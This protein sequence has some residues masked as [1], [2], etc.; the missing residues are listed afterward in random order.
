MKLSNAILICVTAFFTFCYVSIS[1][2][3]L[4]YAPSQYSIY[5]MR[6]GLFLFFFFCCIFLVTKKWNGKE[7]AW[8]KFTGFEKIKGLLSISI[9]FMLIIFC[10]QYWMA[11]PTKWFAH[12]YVVKTMKCVEQTKLGKTTR[13]RVTIHAI[14]F[15][16]KEHISFPWPAHKK[17]ECLSNVNI[18]GYEWFF[19]MYVI[20]VIEYQHEH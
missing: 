19:G 4:P 14:S 9:F 6:Y 5:L 3:I 18:K 1:S 16:G 10:V 8:G 15:D 7:S 11:Y 13:N 12:D 20:D 2:F 17:I